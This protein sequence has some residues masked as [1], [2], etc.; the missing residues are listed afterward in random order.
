MNRAWVSALSMG[1]SAF[2]AAGCGSNL[3]DCNQAAA[4]E[5]VYSSSGLVATKGQA[6]VHDSCGNGAFCHSSAATGDAR[7]GAPAGMNF[8]MLPAPTGWPELMDRRD[9][10]WSLI[11]SGQMPPGKAG[12]EVQGDNGWTFAVNADAN[13]EKL[14]PISTDQGKAAVRNWLACGAPLVNETKQPAWVKPV[15]PR[16]HDFDTIYKTIIAR[17]CAIGGCHNESAAGKLSM[18]DACS[19]YQALLIAG[20]CSMKRVR[21]GDAD[22]LLLDKLQSATP[23]CGGSMPP[24]GRLDASSIDAVRA[25]IVAGAPG[26][27]CN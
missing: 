3:G 9:A 15:A 18:T 27:Q 7:H 21:P 13:S 6:L 4:E 23:R 8:D 19:A 22:S 5:L 14:E 10:A 11:D 16:T 1:L 2:A 17:S 26:P 20:P 25:W 12:A 24:T